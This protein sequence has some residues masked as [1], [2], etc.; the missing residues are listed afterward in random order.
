MGKRCTEADEASEVAGRGMQGG[1]G[2]VPA[3]PQSLDY[4]DRGAPSSLL[5]LQ[6][7]DWNVEPNVQQHSGHISRLYLRLLDTRRRLIFT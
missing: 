4:W 3:T 2:G 6:S 7:Q 1:R 5:L